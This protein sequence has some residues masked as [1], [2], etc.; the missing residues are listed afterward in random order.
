MVVSGDGVEGN[1]RSGGIKLRQL[2]QSL[3]EL[4]QVGGNM[5]CTRE[6]NNTTIK[7]IL[8]YIHVHVYTHVYVSEYIHT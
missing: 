7:N 5:R 3:F 4:S 1:G 6:N 2:R 8:I